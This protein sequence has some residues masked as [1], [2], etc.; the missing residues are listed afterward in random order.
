MGGLDPAKRWA[1]ACA[2]AWRA[3]DGEAAAALF[4]EDCVF[5]S[6]PFR[7]LE[8]A[9]EYTRRNFAQEHDVEAWFGEPVAMADRT[10]VEYWATLIEEDR[11]VTLAGC[12][13]LRLDEG[14][15]CRELKDYWAMRD[16]RIPPPLGWGA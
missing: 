2:R 6:H 16:G 13:V 3:G 12:A 4:T 9:R 5:R 8:D 14:G 10:A 15:R 11:E 7:D 1:D